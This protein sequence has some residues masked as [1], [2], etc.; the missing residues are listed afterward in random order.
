MTEQHP[1]IERYLAT[2][3]T[4]LKDLPSPERSDVVGEIRNHIAEATAAGKPIDAVLASLGPADDLARGYAIELLLNPRSAARKDYSRM[5][6]FLK[7]AGLVAIGSLPTLIVVIILG[8]IGISFTASGIVIFVAGILATADWLPGIVTMDV[9]PWVA[10]LLGP[11]LAAVGAL[12][13][14][15]LVW[16]V[17]FMARLVRRVVPRVVP[18]ASR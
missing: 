18:A 11:V 9:P 8:A 7:L 4:G 16:Y 17:K 13:L 2:L 6:R 15:A 10:V 12:S 1:L 3:E 14:V 5:Q